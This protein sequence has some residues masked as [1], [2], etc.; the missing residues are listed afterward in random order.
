[1]VDLSSSLEESPGLKNFDK[2][3]L[4]FEEMGKVWEQQESA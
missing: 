2:M 4:F 1:V 3:E